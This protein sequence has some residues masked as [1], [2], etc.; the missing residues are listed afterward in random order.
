MQGLEETVAGFLGKDSDD[1]IE[2]GTKILKT[3]KDFNKR[4]GFT[5]KDDRLPKFFREEQL[6]PHNVTFDVT[7]EELDKVFGEI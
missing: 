5:N 4:A 3:E 1:I 7:D 6:P 2:V